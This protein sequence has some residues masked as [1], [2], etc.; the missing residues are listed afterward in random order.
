MPT[1]MPHEMIEILLVEDSPGDVRLTR[2]ALLEARVANRLHVAPNGVEAM[3]FLKRKGKH[4]SAPTPDLV[5]LDLN[6]PRMDGREVLEQMK[7]DSELRRIP[8]II[9]TTSDAEADILRSYDL[10]ANCYLV[11]PVDVDRFFEQVRSIEG[12]WLS[13]VKLPPSSLRSAAA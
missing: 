11:K 4:Q 3:E 9:L 2:E 5:L 1:N 10:H 6:L 13:V 7:S 12:F 8:V